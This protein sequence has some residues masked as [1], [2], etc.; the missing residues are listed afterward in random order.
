MRGST[1]HGH[2]RRKE[3]RREQRSDPGTDHESTPDGTEAV[4][5]DGNTLQ[6]RNERR[7]NAAVLHTGQEA[8]KQLQQAVK[9]FS[10]SFRAYHKILRTA[11]TIADLAGEEKIGAGHMNEAIYYRTGAASYWQRGVGD[12]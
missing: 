8:N 5:T 7:R 9:A 1:C 12:V 6:W 10:L 3:T 4:R 2:K 11:R